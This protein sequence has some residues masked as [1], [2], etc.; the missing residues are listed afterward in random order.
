MPR[1]VILHT[2]DLH[3]KLTPASAAKIRQVREQFPEALLVDA[4]DAVSAG[5]LGFR[6]G[7]EPILRLMSDLRYD[8][9]AMGNRES[10]P[11][12]T[13]L[14]AK[15]SQAKFPV[16]AANLMAKRKPAP[17]Q[18]RDRLV[19]RLRNGLRVTLFGLAPQITKPESW[20]SRMTDYVFDDPI[21]CATGLARK[22]AERADLIICLSHLG[23]K[24]DRELALV[25][26]I[27]VIIGGHSHELLEQPERI[28]NILIAQA[29]WHG[30]FLGKLELEVAEGKTELVSAEL[31]P[32]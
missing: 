3:G 12:R 7:G 19:R 22:L 11:T 31:L 24:T 1:C 5:N 8:A 27:G 6:P 9:M 25:P 13:V 2:N 29:G 15:L 20:W 4:G 16:L 23:L 14:A 21:K 32:L 30:K 17:P 18:V 10:H 26:E 28:G